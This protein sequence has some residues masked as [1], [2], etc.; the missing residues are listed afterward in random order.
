MTEVTEREQELT[1]LR[2][3]VAKLTWIFA[4]TYAVHAPH[5]YVVRGRTCPEDV[6]ARLFNGI[7][8]YGMNQRYGPYRSR[9]LHLGD[10][11]KYWAMTSQLRASRVINRDTVLDPADWPSDQNQSKPKS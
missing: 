5:W 8:Q 7:R 1:A 2:A 11:F 4:K 3:E 10:G 6:Y 9:Y